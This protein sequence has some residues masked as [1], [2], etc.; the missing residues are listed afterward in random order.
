M[1]VVTRH[2]C[3]CISNQEDI[4]VR[5]C[6]DVFCKNKLNGKYLSNCNREHMYLGMFLISIIALTIYYLT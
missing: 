5:K 3:N 4:I 2:P 6:R 1:S